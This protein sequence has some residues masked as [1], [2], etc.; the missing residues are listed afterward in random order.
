MKKLLSFLFGTVLLVAFSCVPVDAG[1]WKVGFEWDAYI[2][3]AD[4]SHFELH[5]AA[6]PGGPYD[7]S[8]IVMDNIAPSTLTDVE[9]TSTKPDGVATTTY[10][11]LKA[12]GNNTE[13]SDPSNEVSFVYDLAPIVEPTD[14]VAA[15]DGDDVTYTWTQADIGR[16]VKWKLYQSET[17]GQDYLELA[18]II[19][20]GQPGP[21]FSTTE[22]MDVPD[23]EKKTFYFVLVAFTEFCVFSQNSIEASVT[24]DKTKPLPVLNFR[25]KIVTQ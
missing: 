19:Y 22:T 5:E 11:I 7:D 20:T 18:E 10:F 17:S 8:T 6:N 1:E 4:A 3:A 15:L 16:V 25:L 23:G 12:V 9:Y 13:K 21:Q 2:D 14:F 24:I